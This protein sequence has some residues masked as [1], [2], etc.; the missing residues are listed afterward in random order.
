MKEINSKFNEFECSHCATLGR[1]SAEA[2]SSAEEK[3][4]KRYCFLEEQVQSLTEESQS[5]SKKNCEFES[6]ISTLESQKVLLRKE[7]ETQVASLGEESLYLKS[8]ID[9]EMGKLTE[10]K[11]STKAQEEFLKDSLRVA[12]QQVDDLR[13]TSQ[14]SLDEMTKIHEVF[15]KFQFEEND[16]VSNHE[17]N[18][19]VYDYLKHKGMLER[20][21][22]ELCQELSTCKVELIRKNG[23]IKVQSNLMA[24]MKRQLEVTKEKISFLR[25]QWKERG[26]LIDNGEQF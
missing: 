25:H 5:L 19:Q 3:A 17:L 6:Q 1:V 11:A 21:C 7:Y 15:L 20:F 9:F 26:L 13:M 22:R 8:M 16:F 12:N 10:M 14:S 18:S 24:R 4:I 23:L 2:L